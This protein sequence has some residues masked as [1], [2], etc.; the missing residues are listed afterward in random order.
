MCRRIKE[1]ISLSPSLQFIIELENAGYVA[2]ANSRTDLSVDGKLRALRLH[3]SRR[4]NHT[5]NSIDAFRLG[6]SNGGFSAKREL[7]TSPWAPLFKDGMVAQWSS[8]TPD[9]YT[10]LQLDLAQLPSINIGTGLKQWR[11]T[12][13]NMNIRSYDMEPAC[14][15]LVL[16][17]YTGAD[18]TPFI[19]PI[20]TPEGQTHRYLFHFRTLST[21]QVHPS[22]LLGTLDCDL[23][24]NAGWGFPVN[25]RGD[26]IIVRPE[27]AGPSQFL[28]DDGAGLIIYNWTTG[29]LLVSLMSLHQPTPIKLIL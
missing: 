26:L 8:V 10:P 15:F 18:T 29:A 2:A 14:D 17:E 3:N 23:H 28:S 5:V 22:A 4:A 6:I 7:L 9:S 21:N 24:G 13:Q 25:C 16:L 12:Q 1:L 19:N 20:L 27:I 11:I